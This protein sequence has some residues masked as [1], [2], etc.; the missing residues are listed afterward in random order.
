MLVSLL[1]LV[2]LVVDIKIVI[3][4]S[5]GQSRQVLRQCS[6][7]VGG[8]LIPIFN[9]VRHINKRR[10]WAL[11]QK[12][13]LLLS[14]FTRTYLHREDICISRKYSNSVTNN[15]RLS[16]DSRLLRLFCHLLL[17]HFHL[18]GDLAD[19]ASRKPTGTGDTE[20]NGDEQLQDDDADL[21]QF[22]EAETHPSHLQTLVLTKAP[23][24]TCYGAMM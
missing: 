10:L 14:L 11:I 5:A 16:L 4:F 13:L 17:L 9:F 18:E 23:S 3:S 2:I 8:S 1:F 20:N 24:T 6:S 15:L 7:S 21:E 22:T 12:L 19:L